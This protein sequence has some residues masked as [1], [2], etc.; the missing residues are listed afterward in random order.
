VRLFPGSLLWRTLIVLVAALV[1][2]QAAALWLLHQQV[3]QPRAALDIV[4]VVS[5]LK[6]ISAALKTLDATQQAEFIGR[7][8]EK[9]GIRIVPVRGNERLRPAPDVPRIH[10]FRERIREIFGPEADVYV[11]PGNPAGNFRRDS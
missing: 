10:L 11:R 3:S 4:Q 1:L 9:E 8:A 7:I 6:T 2:S 5:H